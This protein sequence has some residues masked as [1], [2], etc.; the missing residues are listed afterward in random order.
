MAM[1]KLLLKV[2]S[3]FSLTY[4]FNIIFIHH[5]EHSLTFR[6]PPL[7]D[8]LHDTCLHG[9]SRSRSALELHCFFNTG[10]ACDLKITIAIGTSH[11]FR[12][13]HYTYPPR[14]S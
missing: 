3:F 14:S 13:L 6:F 8:L 5:P 10:A 2:L 9:D 11:S 1:A 4:A 12:S 7:P